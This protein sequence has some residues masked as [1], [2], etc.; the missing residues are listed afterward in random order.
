MGGKKIS[1]ASSWTWWHFAHLVTFR[2]WQQ[3]KMGRILKLLDIFSCW[4]PMLKR[5][6]KSSAHV[7][8]MGGKLSI[9]RDPHKGPRGWFKT[10]KSIKNTPQGTEKGLLRDRQ[11]CTKKGGSWTFSSQK[12]QY[13]ETNMLPIMTPLSEQPHCHYIA[14]STRTYIFQVSNPEWILRDPDLGC[15]FNPNMEALAQHWWLA[16]KT[17]LASILKNREKIH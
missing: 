2:W 9:S 7:F 15:L 14:L 6:E 13:H 16:W 11:L 3:K 8:S 12:V 10:Y 17:T 4:L 5:K 1:S